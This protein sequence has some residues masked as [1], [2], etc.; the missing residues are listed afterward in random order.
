MKA[1]PYV[2]SA[3]FK[4]GA[5]FV[6]MRHFKGERIRLG[7]YV[8]AYAFDG[9]GGFEVSSSVEGRRLYERVRRLERHR[10][11]MT[12]EAYREAYEARVERMRK[13]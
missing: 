8:I 3:A 13:G 5:T 11:N 6:P 2:L 1:D 7:R 10:V 9:E 4:L 12:W